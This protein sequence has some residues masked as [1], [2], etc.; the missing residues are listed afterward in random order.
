MDDSCHYEV[1]A[2]TAKDQMLREIQ[3]YKKRNAELEEQKGSLEEQNGW[4]EQIVASLK[5][6]AYYVET[7]N[8]LKRG[9]S[10]QSIA[11]WLGRPL[12][13]GTKLSP[14][15][16]D[17]LDK[18]VQKYHR[19]FL[20]N[21]D[22]RYWTA[23]TKDIALIEHLVSLYLIWVHPCH[24]LFDEERFLSS[25]KNCVDVYCS[26]ALVNVICATSCLLLDVPRDDEGETSSF[27]RMSFINEARIHLKG[28]DTSKTTTWQAYAISFICEVG[29][30]KGLKAASY[31]RLAT[32]SLV[33]KE[34]I[35]Q[36][37]KS[38]EV[39]SWGVLTLNMFVSVPSLGLVMVLT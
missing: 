37:F 34:K 32:E 21:K 13:S 17:Q 27:L 7:I 10:H 18:A 6:D 22:P 12:V 19:S 38:H 2:K 25:F 9:D 24:M 8:R 33:A 23:A 31:L 3:R 11:E 4:V 28:A 30:G 5:E 29:T 16:S 39:S 35:E 1:H 15:S 36:T 20:V 26:P 14:K